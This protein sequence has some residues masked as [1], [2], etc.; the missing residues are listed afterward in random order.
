MKKKTVQTKKAQPKKRGRPPGSKKKIDAKK[1]LKDGEALKLI[2]YQ[3]YIERIKKGEILTPTEIKDLNQVER[4]IEALTNGKPKQKKV[5]ENNRQAASYC[6]VSTRVI[7][8]H[9]HRGHI[10]QNPDGTFPIES[11]NAWLVKSGRK[12]PPEQTKSG[13]ISKSIPEKIEIEKLKREELRNK[14]EE[15]LLD[16]IRG[17]LMS[18]KE[19]EEQW[20]ARVLIVRSGLLALSNRLPPLIEGKSRREISTIIR[21]EI[22]ELL[23]AYSTKGRYIPEVK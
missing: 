13:E 14:R 3:K 17:K 2:R 18:K 15:I 5:I 16:Q 20:A 23:T 4:D 19:I 9:L 11:L 6:G 10:K 1:L 8:Y 22:I 12:N 7:S 21:A